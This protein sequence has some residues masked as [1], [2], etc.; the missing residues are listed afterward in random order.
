MPED[1]C[2]SVYIT[3]Q[4]SCPWPTSAENQ[5]SHTNGFSASH[6]NT[7]SH[8]SRVLSRRDFKMVGLPAR[9][10]FIFLYP[11]KDNLELK[12]LVTYHICCECKNVYVEHTGHPFNATVKYPYCHILLYQTDKSAVV[13]EHIAGQEIKLL[14]QAHVRSDTVQASSQQH[15]LWGRFCLSSSR[16]PV[17]CF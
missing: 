10:I 14:G 8:I 1:F 17:I 16:K 3:T 11:I 9:K 6:P 5:K 7:F 15:E 12:T 13:V 2:N 4:M